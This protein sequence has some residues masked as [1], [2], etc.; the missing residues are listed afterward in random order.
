MKKIIL[1]IFGLTLL[2][3][4]QTTS[5]FKNITPIPDSEKNSRETG[6]ILYTGNNISPAS[7]SEELIEVTGSISGGISGELKLSTDG[8]TLL[9][10][11]YEKYAPGE[12]VSV[13]INAGLLESSGS[14]VEPVSFSFSVTELVERLDPYVYLEEQYREEFPER[15]AAPNKKMD[16]PPANFP[17]ISTEVL[18]ETAD[19]LVFMN[20]SRDIDGVG[21]FI[22]AMN[23]DGTPGYYKELPHDYSYNFKVQPNGMYSYS[24]LFEH[25]S[26]TGG[27]NVTHYVMDESFTVVDSFKMGNGYV[28]EA[29]DFVLLPNGHALLFGYDLQKRDL[30]HLGGYPNALVAQTVVQELDQ[31]KNVVFQWRSSDHYEL[32]DSYY[33]RWERSAL[34][35]VHVNSIIK[36][37]DG[38]ILITSNG[39]SEVTKISR[40]TGEMIWRWG[41]KINEF[42][43]IGENAQWA[44]GIHNISRLENGNILLFDNTPVRS[45]LTS[46]AVEYELDEVNK[47]ATLVWHY[48]PEEAV[49]GVRRGS[50]QRLPNGNTIIGWGSASD[51]DSIAVTEVTPEGEVVFNLYFNHVGMASYRAFRYPVTD[52]TPAAE[53]TE[54]EVAEGNTY[55]LSDADNETGVDVKITAIQ[56]AGYNEFRAK[57]INF[58]PI[59]PQFLGKAPHVRTVRITTSQSGINSCAYELRFDAEFLGIPDPENYL[60]YYR[61]FEDNGVFQLLNTSYNQV[62]GEITGEA[63]GFGEFILAK[64]DF[65]SQV[66]KPMP[67][68][69]QMDELVN[70]EL[71]VNLR[72][73]P[74]GYVN[75]YHL[76]ISDQNDF[77]NLLVDEEFLTEAIYEFNGLQNG[78]TYY[79]R[80]NST[81][82]AGTSDWSEVYTFDATEPYVQLSVPNG[83]DEIQRGIDH[84]IIWEDNLAEDVEIKLSPAANEQWSLI[85]VS[86]STGG[87]RWSVD[88]GQEPGEYKIKI[89]SIVDTTIFSVSESAFSI[90]DTVSS[91]EYEDVLVENYSLNQ[92][93]P[94]PFNPSTKISF[95]MPNRG[96]AVISVFSITGELMEVVASGEFA[97]GRHSVDF[98]ADN[99]SSGIYLYRLQTAEYTATKKMILI[100]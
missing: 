90:I 69:P 72:W 3:S 14:K 60:V 4:A 15:Y 67:F 35:P 24:H 85:D 100:K 56:G 76:Q 52:Y 34:D 74:I 25:H 1:F 5:I 2:L 87:Y 13:N 11:P 97:A 8:K 36:D 63:S 31:D 22:M 41:G 37:T 94:N 77:S 92:N 55:D 83:G 26:Y 96:I 19:G 45:D 49:L 10:N 28:A 42:T 29:H 33:S 99:Y 7:L 68:E 54:Y 23:N 61:E 6:I 20:V 21:F 88:P 32:S 84:F 65:E 12:V 98:R 86:E 30:T 66:F 44:N 95:E 50:A 78:T 9:F 51:D 80:V 81:N 58:A 47:T 82:D 70:Y 64:P 46:R 16:D 40:E 39:H 91:V 62:T 18:G 38:N 59:E 53:F 27:G 93:Y 57:R 73:A 75:E 71:S 79:W 89:N 43:F 17:N 48:T